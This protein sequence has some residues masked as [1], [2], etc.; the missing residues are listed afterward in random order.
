MTAFLKDRNELLFDLFQIF[1]AGLPEDVTVVQAEELIVENRPRPPK[2][3]MTYKITS[4][5]TPLGFDDNIRRNDLRFVLSSGR[6]YTV[7]LQFFGQGGYDSLAQLIDSFYLDGVKADGSFN[8]GELTRQKGIAIIDRGTP[9][10]ISAVVSVGFER[11]T[12]LDIRILTANNIDVDIAAI[13]K[14]E[15]DAT[16]KEDDKD[17]NINEIIDNS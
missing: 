12:A 10:D 1:T 3:Y 11:R 2:P 5:P 16:I 8:V 6:A 13:D 7:S 17:F 15:I 9:Q 4:G 14:V